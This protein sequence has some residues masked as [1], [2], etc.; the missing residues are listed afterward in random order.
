LPPRLGFP[1]FNAD[2]DGVPDDDEQATRP[3]APVATRPAVV[4]DTLRKS[5]RDH[6]PAPILSST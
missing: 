1:A 5:R 3:V 2:V 6:D 4:P